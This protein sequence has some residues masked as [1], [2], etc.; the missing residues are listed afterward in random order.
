MPTRGKKPKIR[1]LRWTALTNLQGKGS[2]RR[3]D[4]T[5][6]R[7]AR[8]WGRR[9]SWRRRRRRRCRGVVAVVVAPRAAAVRARD[10]VSLRIHALHVRGIIAALQ[11]VPGRARCACAVTR[12]ND[13]ASA[14]AYCGT[15]SSTAD[16]S[17]GSRADDRAD[18]CATHSTIRKCF[19][20]GR[21]ATLIVGVL[22]ALAVIGAELIKILG[23]A[24]KHRHAR[25]GR[26]RR[27]ASC[28]QCD[29]TKPDDNDARANHQ[30]AGCGETRCHPPGHSFT[31]G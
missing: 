20:I 18:R 8:R 14:C 31:Y 10:L 3:D 26:W 4:R 21:T 27:D 7:L 15:G 23:R 24:R 28:E 16:Q 1:Q 9:S 30:R 5:P 25:A 13:Q 29:C 17:S 6:D 12:A 11:L 19:L 2:P 22:T